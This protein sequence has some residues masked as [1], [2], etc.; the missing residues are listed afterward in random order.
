MKS[1]YD[2]K[3]LLSK[4]C[5]YNILFGKRSNGKSYQAKLYALKDFLE[6]G[7]QFIYLRR[8]VNEIKKELVETYF[9]DID[10]QELTNGEYTGVAVKA[11]K[12][13]LSTINDKG[14]LVLGKQIGLIWCLVHWQNYKSMALPKV[15]TII[16]EEFMTSSFYLC[17]EPKKLENIYSTV[18]RNNNIVRM[19]L[20]GNSISRINPYIDGWDI[21]KDFNNIKIGQIKVIDVITANGSTKSIAIEYC[22]NQ[23]GSG[24]FIASNMIDSGDFEVELQPLL[25]GSYKDYKVNYRFVFQYK[26]FKFICEYLSKD[27]DTLFFVYPK[28]NSIKKDTIVIG[29]QIEPSIYYQRNIYDLKTRNKRLNQLLYTFSETNLFFSDHRTG[30]EFKQLVDFSIRK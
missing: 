2:I 12:F 5:L 25:P 17:D 9:D 26:S 1:Y 20:I 8:T 14:K 23:G 7:N 16:F 3:D 29:D 27:K 19:F 4:N 11:N 13:Y 30:T 21:R 24:N 22:K 10:I 15:R 6:N 28:Y 18:D